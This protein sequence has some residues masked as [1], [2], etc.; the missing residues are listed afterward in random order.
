MVAWRILLSLCEVDV[1]GGRVA[2]VAAVGG[3]V[4]LTRLW[5]DAAKA[6]KTRTALAG[7]VVMV[8][9]VRVAD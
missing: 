3:V 6:S 9:V 4:L 7:V 1:V 5:T 8:V 2:G